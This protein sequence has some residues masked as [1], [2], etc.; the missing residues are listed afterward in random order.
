[1][2]EKLFYEVQDCRFPIFNTTVGFPWLYFFILI[3]K[4]IKKSSSFFPNKSFCKQS[5]VL[6]QTG[7]Q[8]SLSGFLK[9][10]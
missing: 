5:K 4:F 7:D 9:K 2:F 1:M 10:H 8:R 3:F 6:V